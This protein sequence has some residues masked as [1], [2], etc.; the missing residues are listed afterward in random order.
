MALCD[1]MV[2]PDRDQVQMSFRAE[3]G[4]IVISEIMADPIPAVE[5]PP[6]EYIEIFNRSDNTINLAKWRLSS[7]DQN[8]FFPNLEIFHF[9]AGFGH[10]ADAFMAEDAGVF[11]GPG[12]LVVD[13][14]LVGPGA[15]R[16][17]EI[18][19][20]A[21]V[22]VRNRGGDVFNPDFALAVGNGGFHVIS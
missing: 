12:Q 9:G 19:A 2:P 21:L 17:D 15:G 3:P 22:G 18:P 6:E 20:Q 14:L 10:D 8:S 4:D 7:A 11:L 13:V 1:L 16:A 5:L